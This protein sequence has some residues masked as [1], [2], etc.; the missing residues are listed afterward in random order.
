M[1]SGKIKD[2]SITRP[3]KS[4]MSATT[5]T[6]IFLPLEGVIDLNT[7]IDKLKRDFD[8]AQKDFDKVDKKLQN[9][10]FIDNAPDDVIEKVKQEAQEFREKLNSLTS[11]L[12]NFQ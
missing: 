11:S 7:F 6:E 9:P 4:I 10:Q 1:K 12:E 5:H 3:E 2:K 8:K